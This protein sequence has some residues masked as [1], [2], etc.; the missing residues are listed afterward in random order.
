MASDHIN[1][2]KLGVRQLFNHIKTLSDCEQ[3]QMCLRNSFYHEFICRMSYDKMYIISLSNNDKTM[4]EQHLFMCSQRHGTQGIQFDIDFAYNI[5]YTIV[6][7]CLRAATSPVTD[8][9]LNFTSNEAIESDVAA[10]ILL[11]IPISDANSK[12][13]ITVHL[14]ENVYDVFEKVYRKIATLRKDLVLHLKTGVK[15]K[16]PSIIDLTDQQ[17]NEQVR[18]EEGNNLEQENSVDEDR[19]IRGGSRKKL[20]RH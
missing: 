7:D 9:H 12:R 6:Y 15:R 19:G 4:I 5:H 8:I 20:R 13:N 16:S 10:D 3:Y 11:S 1:V 18:R 2:D 17:P 14:N